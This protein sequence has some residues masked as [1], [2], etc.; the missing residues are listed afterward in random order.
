MRQVKLGQTTW[1]H[2][3]EPDADD[4]LAIGKKFNLHP[5]VIE[6]FSTP[7]LRPKAA[8]YDNC[9]YLTIHVP[10]FDTENKTT[11][12]G[13]IDVVICENVLITSHDKDIYQLTDFFE[14]LKKNKKKRDVF[15]GK[16]PGALL[17]YIV[18][19]LM[20]SCFPKLDHISRKLD[21]V[22]E[23]IFAGNEKEMVLEISVVKRDILNFRRTMKPQRSIFESLAQKDYKL[24]ERQLKPY[25]Q[26]LIGTNIRLW[27]NLESAKETVESLEDTN[28]SLLSNK[29]DMTMKILTIFSAVLLPM[30]V[31]SNI[32]AMSA[33]IPFSK[34]PHAFWI[35]FSIML[36]VALV[37][38][39]TFR[40]KKWL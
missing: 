9:L 39:T 25:Y 19:M 26:D 33:E 7:T 2:F 4:V 36:L 32:L 37:T 35:H 20:E 12:P 38:I 15:S 10:L 27:N 29:L 31:Y 3:K 18:E 6:E 21:Y 40:I 23:Q 11:Y 30:T 34:N 13:E 17:H 22:E 1:I 14:E 28:N 8:E 24:I 16:S 5:L